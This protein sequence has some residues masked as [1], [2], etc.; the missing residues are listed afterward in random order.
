MIFKITKTK[1]AFIVEPLDVY[2]WTAWLAL[3]NSNCTCL[4]L[5]Y[6]RHAAVALVSHSGD[7]HAVRAAAQQWE[8][9]AV[10]LAAAA[11]D[12]VVSRLHKCKETLPAQ[13]LI[14]A[15][16]S[17]AAL[18]GVCVLQVCRGAG[19]W[20]RDGYTHFWNF[21]IMHLTIFNT[22]IWLRLITYL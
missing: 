9:G 20:G 16:D 7:L 12:C 21:F 4:Y 2:S 22:R 14:P 5:C 6:P 13:S 3:V 1:K 18:T 19:S 17:D 11:G 15:Q 8:Q 10:G